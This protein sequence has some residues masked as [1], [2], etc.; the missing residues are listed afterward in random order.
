MSYWTSLTGHFDGTEMD[1]IQHA[2]VTQV[3][4]NSLTVTEEGI[5]YITPLMLMRFLEEVYLHDELDTLSEMMKHPEI[6]FKRC[7][8][9]IDPEMLESDTL[10]NSKLVKFIAKVCNIPG[11]WVSL[12]GYLDTY[13]MEEIETA[14]IEELIDVAMIAGPLH[15][16]RIMAELYVRADPR[17]EQFATHNLISVYWLEYDYQH[18]STA[19]DQSYAE[20][21]SSIAPL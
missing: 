20:L 5:N 6:T 11:K 14:H 10:F 13:Q 3:A 18:K 12:T 19:R 9:I 15:T 4:E 8:Y 1:W 2:T 7:W 17:F 16:L 21:F